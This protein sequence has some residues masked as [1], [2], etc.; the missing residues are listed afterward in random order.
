MIAALFSIG[1]WVKDHKDLDVEA[2]KD[3]YEEL[4]INREG[5]YND[6][7]TRKVK[8]PL[9]N[10]TY[11]KNEDSKI[12]DF[13]IAN[14]GRYMQNKEMT[15]QQK[16]D[17]TL[18]LTELSNLPKSSIFETDD[19]RVYRVIPTIIRKF[20]EE[21]RIGTARRLLTRSVRHGVDPKA[22]DVRLCK[23]IVNTYKGDIEL[24]LNHKV[25]ASM[26]SATYNV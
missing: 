18:L 2:L 23:G 9:E 7:I 4:V 17:L 12:C 14:G 25:R 26:K 24:V 11:L 5:V 1:H 15:T 13:E 8:F 19:D 10:S 20:A 22:Y 3:M 21:S 16:I 6:T